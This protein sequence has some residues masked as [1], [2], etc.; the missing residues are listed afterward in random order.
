[1]SEPPAGVILAPL[2]IYRVHDAFGRPPARAL[3][4]APRH[5]VNSSAD[6]RKQTRAGN[7]RS[8]AQA[9]AAAFGLYQQLL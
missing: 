7:A 9:Q 6:G 3:A 5:A 1:M 2:Y 4:L 8:P